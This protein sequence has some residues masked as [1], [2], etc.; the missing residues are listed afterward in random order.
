[1]LFDD[2]TRQGQDLFAR[3][4]K[5]VQEIGE[6]VRSLKEQN[7]ALNQELA[8]SREELEKLRERVAFY[9]DERREL[10]T[11]VEDLLKDFEKVS[12]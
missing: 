1:M 5:K 12:G 3:L 9:E 8:A 10:Q 4:K 7:A 6:A 2:E 11:V